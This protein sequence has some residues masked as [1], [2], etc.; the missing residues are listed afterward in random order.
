V[1]VPDCGHMVSLERPDALLDAM[2]PFLRDTS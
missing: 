2:L 1:L